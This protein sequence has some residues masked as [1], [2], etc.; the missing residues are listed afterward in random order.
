MTERQLRVALHELADAV[1]RS[2][3]AASAWAGA[4]RRRIRRR[5]VT[6]VVGATTVAVALAVVTYIR[7][8]AERATLRPPVNSPIASA[9]PSVAVAPGREEEASLPYTDSPLPRSVK[10]SANAPQLSKNPL[11][12]GLALFESWNELSSPPPV[13]VLGD[14]GRLRELDQ[15]HLA[16]VAGPDGNRRLPLSSGSLA[17]DGTRAAFPQKDEI[18]LVDLRTGAARTLPLR[19]FNQRV[20]WSSGSDL[21]LVSQ[22][23]GTALLTV[24]TGAV[25]HS[26]ASTPG[27]GAA[28]LDAPTWADLRDDG[29]VAVTSAGSLPAV[30]GERVPHL[31]QWWGGAF[32]SGGLVARG[33]FS[34]DLEAVGVTTNHPQM[35]VVVDVAHPATSRMLAFDWTGRSKGCCAAL[36][37]FGGHTVLVSSEDGSGLTRVLAWDLDTGA[38]SRITEVVG[39]TTI[40]LASLVR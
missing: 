35:V 37:W 22:G 17:P 8:P 38:V 32:A 5:R 25:D 30:A 15:M 7:L 16:W 26:G 31:G 40:S 29:T 4:Q 20:T 19:G 12:R 33:A 21:L 36:G 39:A 14:D 9:Q 6:A 28:F 23:S 1:E 18:V 24:A 10:L 27:W 3:L 34:T 11:T 2:D 13:Q